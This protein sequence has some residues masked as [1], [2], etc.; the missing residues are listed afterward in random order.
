MIEVRILVT[1]GSRVA[2]IG[3]WHLGVS[4]RLDNILFLD[5]DDGY[6]DIFV[7]WA[8]IKLYTYN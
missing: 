2:V 6:I 8:F 4:E 3:V 7:L 5:L 1:F